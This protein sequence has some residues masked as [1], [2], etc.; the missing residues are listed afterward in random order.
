MSILINLRIARLFALALAAW[1]IA[2]PSA[3]AEERILSFDSLITVQPDGTLVVS[4]TIRVRAEGRNIRRGIYREF[5]TIYPGKD[6]R[7]VIVGFAFET[8]TRDGRP[9]PWRTEQVGNGVRIYLGSASVM[10]PPGEH[11]Y[12]IVYRTDRQMGFFA[13]HDELYWNVTGTEWDFPI[14]EASATVTLPEGVRAEALDF[15]TGG[16]GATG[17][18]ARASRDGSEIYFATTHSL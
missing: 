13:D 4:D 11:T 17:K 8:A 6:G 1:S 16:Y 7:Q 2:A 10:L 5:P 15:F 14:D 9:E 3:V 12:E 18:D